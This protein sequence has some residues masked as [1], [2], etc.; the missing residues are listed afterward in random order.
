MDGPSEHQVTAHPAG[1]RR[2]LPEPRRR[3]PAPGGPGGW[4]AGSSL[5][6]EFH[7]RQSWI[8]APVDVEPARPERLRVVEG[9]L[10]VTTGAERRVFRAGDVV[11]LPALRRSTLWNAGVG[12]VRLV[13]D[14]SPPMR[15]AQWL[16]GTFPV[17]AAPPTRR[18]VVGSIAV[19]GA[20]AAAAGVALRVW[21]R[22]R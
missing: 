10:G 7:L 14:Y 1:T 13:D 2:V 11:E 8:A 12:T 6:P 16:E 21:R 18:R 4:Q 22:R 20:V 3:L 19:V 15:R 17:R 9:R 5:Q